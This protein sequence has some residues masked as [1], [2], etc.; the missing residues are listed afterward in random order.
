[1]RARMA[2]AYVKIKIELREISLKDRPKELYKASSKGTIPV[3]I[4]TDEL[5]IDESL[6]IMIWLLKN[7]QDQTWLNDNSKKELDLINRNDTIFK[8][9]LDRYKYHDR[10]P[11]H[12]KKYYRKKCRDILSDHENQLHNMKYLPKELPSLISDVDPV[13]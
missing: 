11:E 3:L 5:V 10:Y 4:T 6:D 13:Q 9:W 8:K 1:M 2:L 12:S 7:K